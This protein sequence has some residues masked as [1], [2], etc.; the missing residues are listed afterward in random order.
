M[1]KYNHKSR[2]VDIETGEILT[3]KNATTN[4]YVIKK[5]KSYDISKLIKHTAK[6]RSGEVTITWTNICRK[7]THKQTQL[8]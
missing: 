3:K 1:I 6:Y 8:W 4:Y 5:E 2:Y 7:Q